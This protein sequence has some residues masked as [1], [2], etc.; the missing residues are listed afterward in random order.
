MC[1]ATEENLIKLLAEKIEIKQNSLAFFYRD[2]LCIFITVIDYCQPSVLP[3]L[4]PLR[5]NYSPSTLTQ[6]TFIGIKS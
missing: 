5:M 1:I 2:S 3:R 4:A 6:A